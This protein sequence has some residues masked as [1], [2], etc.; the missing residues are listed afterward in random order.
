MQGTQGTWISQ[1][2]N[3]HRKLNSFTLE[4]VANQLLKNP[5]QRQKNLQEIEIAIARYKMFLYLQSLYPH[6]QLV[7]TQEID[8]IWH[9]H[10]LMNTLEYIQDCQHLFGRIVHHASFAEIPQ[11][12]NRTPTLALTQTLFE[13]HFGKG[14]FAKEVKSAACGILREE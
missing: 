9:T 7:P 12:E 13:L 8:E 10:I 6:V 4:K 5:E 3:S 14:S 2:G 11:K 1:P